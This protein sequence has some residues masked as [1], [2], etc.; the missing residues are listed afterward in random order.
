M[1]IVLE[2]LDMP[3]KSANK[4]KYYTYSSGILYDDL[5]S[6]AT[7]GLVKA[8]KKYDGQRNFRTYAYKAIHNQLYNYINKELEEE[9]LVRKLEIQHNNY[10]I[11][12]E[13]QEIIQTLDNFNKNL[14]Y[15][16]FI[17]DKT[18]KVIAK[19]LNCSRPQINKLVNKKIK[20]LK[21]EY[22]GK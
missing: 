18:D 15:K 3:I 7:L 9:K 19:E 5:L 22:N 21:E 13:A 1:D 10:K 4:L 20:E 17:E 2:N 8:S 16:K 6:E 14:F 11:I 12:S